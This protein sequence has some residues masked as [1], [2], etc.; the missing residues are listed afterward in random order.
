[1]EISD[2]KKKT[3]S[4]V[5]WRLAERF[6]AQFISFIVSIVLAR[7][8][9]PEEYGIVALVMVFINIFNA[10]VTNGLGASL[11]QKKDADEIDFS[12]MFYS[13][14][15]LSI[16]LFIILCLMS[17]LISK[18]Y[19]IENLGIVLIVMGLKMPI[20]SISSIQQ[21][22]ISKKME[23][24]K[25]FYATLIGTIISGVLGIVAAVKGLGVWAL[26]IQYLSNSL[27]DTIVLFIVVNWKP[28]FIF[29]YTRFK[30]LFSYGYKVMLTGVI[31]TVFDQLKNFIIGLRYTSVDLAYYNRG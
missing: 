18:M 2:I 19:N 26:V 17:P 31:G 3:I 7:I 10:F 24:K 13:G 6:L 5:F 23:Y 12:T 4:G 29:S 22:Y 20:A 16:V 11:I 30:S 14:L 1:M 25:F 9:L 27:I 8:L 15:A 21:A 28:R